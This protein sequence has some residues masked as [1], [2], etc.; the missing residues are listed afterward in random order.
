MSNR[1]IEISSVK[2]SPKRTIVFS[3]TANDNGNVIIGQK[4]TV[5]DENGKPLNFFM[6]GAMNIPVNSL[7]DFRDAVNLVL[8]SLE[9]NEK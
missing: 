8:K 4:L 9:E 1:F 7:Y 6:K 2:I 3:Q 5:K